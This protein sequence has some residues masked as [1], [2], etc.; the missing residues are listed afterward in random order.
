MCKCKHPHQ[1]MDISQLTVGV[2][3]AFV[4]ARK[5]A[6][7]TYPD[8]DIHA[9]VMVIAGVV[10]D[11]IA[12]AQQAGLD[13]M[14][15]NQLRHDVPNIT[16]SAL[17]GDVLGHVTSTDFVTVHQDGWGYVAYNAKVDHPTLAYWTAQRIWRGWDLAATYFNC[18]GPE[19]I[20]TPGRDC[21]VVPEDLWLADPRIH[22]VYDESPT[23]LDG[24]SV[25]TRMDEN[26]RHVFS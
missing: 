1:V 19:H 3:Y 16:M 12:L 10:S 2:R 11:T 26:L 22:A 7:G 23:D 9:R 20:T 17:L 21:I 6:D 25:Q 14:Q 15:L 4:G 8:V 18:S 24:R 5:S 13:P